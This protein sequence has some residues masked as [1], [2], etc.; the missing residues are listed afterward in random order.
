M[1]GAG[2]CAQS[3]A[4]EETLL[5]ACGISQDPCS[6]PLPVA[7]GNGHGGGPALLFECPVGLQTPNNLLVSQSHPASCWLMFHKCGNLRCGQGLLWAAALPW[8]ITCPAPPLPCPLW[9][10][11]L[12]TLHPTSHPHYTPPSPWRRERQLS[13]GNLPEAVGPEQ[14]S[15]HSLRWDSLLH[16]EGGPGMAALG[17]MAEQGW[18]GQKEHG[19]HGE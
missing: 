10:L 8:L 19:W 4:E 18:E 5:R 13:E 6:S 12:T 1:L 16:G 2:G 7:M 9:G 17:I 15:P 3:D 11:T 14:H